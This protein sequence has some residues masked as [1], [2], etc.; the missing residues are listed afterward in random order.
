[1]QEEIKEVER[2]DF[3]SQIKEELKSRD[4]QIADLKDQFEKQGKIMVSMKEL[5]E[6]VASEPA[7]EPKEKRKFSL[8]RH[9]ESKGELRNEIKGNPFI[10]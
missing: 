5:L 3:V 9:K 6:I 4:E 2:V 8:T 10:K 1:M 7:A